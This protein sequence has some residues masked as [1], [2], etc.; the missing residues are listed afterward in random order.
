MSIWPAGGSGGSEG[1]AGSRLFDSYADYE[2]LLASAQLLFAMLG[3]GALLTPA[4]FV[5]VF[6]RPAQLVL[7]LALQLGMVPLVAVAI[8]SVLTL[9]VGVAAGLALVA[10]VPGG[11]VSNILTYFARGNIALSISLTA[12][13]TVASLATTPLLLRLLAGTHLP[14]DFEMPTGRIA[15]EIGAILLLP[16]AAGMGVGLLFPRRRDVFS[17]WCI[18]TSFFFIGLMVVGGAGAGRLD[19]AAHGAIGPIAI[20]LLCVAIQAIAWA[21][22]RAFGLTAPDRVAIGIEVT[23]RNTNLA[24]LVKASLFPAVTGIPDPIG[25]GMFYVALLYGA[26]ALPLSM[27]PLYQGRRAARQEPASPAPVTET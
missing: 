14:A 6:R 2:Y 16:L 23:I 21:A 15:F 8:A 12:V 18:R 26:A 1:R 22:T 20:V 3:M 10:A 9:P 11:T 13:T 25:D 17:R 19:P 24:L 4:D 5:A 7:G 27:I